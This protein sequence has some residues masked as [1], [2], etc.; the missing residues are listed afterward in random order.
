M[1]RQF[2]KSNFKS[3]VIKFFANK[4]PADKDLE[5][6]IFNITA[7]KS[8]TNIKTST[9]NIYCICKAK[10]IRFKLCQPRTIIPIFKSDFDHIQMI[11][12]PA[13]LFAVEIISQTLKFKKVR[14]VY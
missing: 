12:V 8:D 1:T 2:L 14:L 7:A 13:K 5:I 3:Q 11:P 9:V 4:T 6:I 10:L